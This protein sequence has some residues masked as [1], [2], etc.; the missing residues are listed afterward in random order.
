[1]TLIL[2]W[3][4]LALVVFTYVGFPLLAA[5]RGRL[6]RRPYR[7]G[8]I[9][10]SVSVVIAARNEAG[11]IGAKIENLWELDY[12]A[13]RLEVV[14][15]SDGSTDATEQIVRSYESGHG[16][17]AGLSCS[18]GRGT[19]PRVRLLSLA[20]QGK[21]AALNAA[22]PASRGDVLVFTDANSM[23]LPAAV[24]ELV[25]PLA[26]PEIGG[27]AGDQRYV[28]QRQ[29]AATGDGERIYWDLDRRLKQWES[30][31]GNVIS[32]TGAIYAI[33]RELFQTVP[34][35]VTDD[36]VT[37]TRVIAQGRRL[38]FAPRAV[39]WEPIA[40]T[41]RVEF[42]RKVRIM[43]R[44]LRGVFMMRE[45]L[46]PFRFGF[47]SLQLFCHKVLRRQMALPLLLVL[48]CSALLWP[49]GF[50]YQ[51][52]LIGQLALYGC[53]A[54]G[55]LLHNTPWGRHKVLTLPWYF[56]VVN[57][58]SLWATFKWFSGT[59]VVL[60]EPQRSDQAAQPLASAVQQ[61]RPQAGGRHAITG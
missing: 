42:G 38:V 26:D 1:V 33:R 58:A 29:R 5:V 52:V 19:V 18:Q 56:C 12:P 50:L 3:L 27:V 31:A 25:R 37:S 44:G 22:V 11:S 49:E 20:R 36:F 30:Q 23:F 15:A 4:A 28:K 55:L 41:S 6:L 16:A 57:A 60:W 51:A 46:N 54:L 7:S 2:F 8:E 53:A 32:A 59:R 14:V 61:A 45:L 48:A 13:D 9:T 47:Y 24:R 10:P 17:G 34:E 35:G 40:G 21:A 39:A 43:L